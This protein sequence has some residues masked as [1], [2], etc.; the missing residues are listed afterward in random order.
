MK[1]IL[2]ALAGSILKFFWIKIRKRL[3]NW[4]LKFLLRDY[5]GSRC[6]CDCG[7]AESK[8]ETG[9]RNI[10]VQVKA[11]DQVVTIKVSANESE[12]HSGPET[13]ALT[14]R[15]RIKVRQKRLIRLLQAAAED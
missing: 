5:V 12:S 1:T 6:D 10:E 9:A 13:K 4:V 11:G 15:S 3:A 2:Q 8:A 7:D 14:D